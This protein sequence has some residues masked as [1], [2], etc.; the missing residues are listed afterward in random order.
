LSCADARLIEAK[1]ISSATALSASTNIQR[2][3]RRLLNMVSSLD[4][5]PLIF[6]ETGFLRFKWI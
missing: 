6:K 5:V 3:A 4:L 1:L 2:I